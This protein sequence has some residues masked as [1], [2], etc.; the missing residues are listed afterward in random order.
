MGNAI[1]LSNKNV[2][3]QTT[4]MLIQKSPSRLNLA[5]A[6]FKMCLLKAYKE[7]SSL[8]RFKLCDTIVLLDIWLASY[9]SANAAVSLFDFKRATPRLLSA[10]EVSW[11]TLKRGASASFKSAIALVQTSSACA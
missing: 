6:F 3:V 5:G 7:S 4:I 2:I 8:A 9:K 10:Y 1:T 11:R